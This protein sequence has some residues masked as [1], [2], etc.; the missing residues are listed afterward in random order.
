MDIY[1]I[2][3]IP[4]IELELGIISIFLVVSLTALVVTR[5]IIVHRHHKTY[6]IDQA[7]SAIFAS[8]GM[9][10]GL[11]LGLVAVAAWQ[12]HDKLKELVNDEAASI[13]QTYRT[14]SVLKDPSHKFILDDLKGYTKYVIEEAWPAHRRGLKPMAGSDW[15]S[16]LNKKIADYNSIAGNQTVGYS[17]AVSAFSEMIKARRLRVYSIDIGIP[18]ALWI[19]IISGAILTIPITFF[20]HIPSLRTHMLLTG[21]Y[22]VFLGGI[23]SLIVI[24]D[25]PM[26]GE[27]SVSPK[28]YQSALQAMEQIDRN[29]QLLK[30][31]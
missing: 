1:W 14:I 28:P 7:V 31:N 26:R 21:F 13:V 30:N 16:S 4:S 8:V 23:V 17:E 18:A 27:L 24:L 6:D 29:H 9:L 11:L 3:D 2:Y 19:V 15:I 12:N 5:R 22:V 25:N 20:F 10:Y